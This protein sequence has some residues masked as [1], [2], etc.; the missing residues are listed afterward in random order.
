MGRMAEAAVAWQKA[1]ELG[2]NPAQRLSYGNFLL[3]SGKVE[4]AAEVEATL[5]RAGLPARGY[6]VLHPGT[7][8][9]GAFKRWPIAKWSQ[10]GAMLSR[11]G[12][13]TVVFAW[14]PGER[15]MAEEAARGALPAIVLSLARFV[16]ALAANPPS[17][18]ILC[19][20][21]KL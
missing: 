5:A 13:R 4:E 15:G 16:V 8:G 11:E 17:V 20:S 21:P 12:R 10:V 7:S 2:L 9:F 19:Q 18:G 3:E 6:A 14:G 1:S